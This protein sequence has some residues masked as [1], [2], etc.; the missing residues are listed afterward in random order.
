[1]LTGHE[2]LQ[3]CED[4]KFSEKAKVEIKGIPLQWPPRGVRFVRGYC[5]GRYPSRKMTSSIQLESRRLELPCIYQIERNNKVLELYDQPSIQT[6]SHPQ[7]GRSWH[8][9]VQGH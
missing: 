2:L 5:S 4:L 1:V 9:R 7:K 3:L 6:T 8:R